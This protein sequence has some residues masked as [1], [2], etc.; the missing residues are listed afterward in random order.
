M[1]ARLFL[2]FTVVPAVELYLLIRVGQWLG[3]AGTVVFVVLTGAL[4]AALAR[5]EGLGVIH[6]WREG[7]VRGESPGDGLVA[8]LLVLV[9]GL[10]LV[11]P[12]VLTDLTGLL[13]LFPPTRRLL[14]PRVKAWL[15][16]H[17]HV[18]GV[19]V[20]PVRPGPAAR[21]VRDGFDHPTA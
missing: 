18:E 7:A 10:L 13:L 16:R 15:V 9:G 17:V 14:A 2:L 11:A 12:G 3:A 1:L 6:R 20:G 21:A 4:G 19:Q 5:R 8:A